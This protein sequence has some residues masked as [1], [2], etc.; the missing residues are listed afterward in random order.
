MGRL[1]GTCALR[2]G[3]GRRVRDVARRRWRPHARR[4]ARRGPRVRAERRR[5]GG[6]RDVE[7]RRSAGG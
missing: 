1:R 4:F 6:S 7:A 2:G 5:M 3:G